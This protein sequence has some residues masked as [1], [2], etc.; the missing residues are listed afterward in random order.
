[1]KIYCYDS[2]AIFNLYQMG[3]L[4]L[5]VQTEPNFDLTDHND[6]KYVISNTN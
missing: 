1:M 3:R 4:S 2:N 6:N 5:S